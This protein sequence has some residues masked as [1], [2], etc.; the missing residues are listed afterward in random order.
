M[1]DKV[2]GETVEKWLAE[3]KEA[4]IVRSDAESARLLGMLP[5]TLCYMKK[6]GTDNRTALAFRALLH[7][8]EPYS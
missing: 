2:T 6:N 1:A 4:G 8:M 3:M 5:S 7:R